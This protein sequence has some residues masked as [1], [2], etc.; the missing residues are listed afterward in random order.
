MAHLD[1]LILLALRND[2]LPGLKQFRETAIHA[3]SLAPN[4]RGRMRV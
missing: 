1:S 4:R 2:S 3:K